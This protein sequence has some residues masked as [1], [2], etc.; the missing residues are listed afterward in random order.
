MN[1]IYGCL[2]F[3]IRR[4]RQYTVPGLTPAPA[5]Q[6]LKAHEWCSRPLASAVLLKGVRPNCSRPNNQRILEHSPLFQVAKEGGDGL[7][8]IFGQ[9]SVVH[10]IAVRV[11][12]PG[13]PLINQFHETDTAFRKTSWRR[14]IANRKPLVSGH[15]ASRRPRECGRLPPEN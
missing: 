13:R 10:H 6:E 7:I 15:A 3:R 2:H 5:S 14:D 11:P 4:S 12:I 9:R 8:D 1:R